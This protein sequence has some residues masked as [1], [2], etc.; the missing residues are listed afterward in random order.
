MRALRTRAACCAIAALATVIA[1]CGD[2]RQGGSAG[3]VAELRIGTFDP[4]GVPYIAAMLSSESLIAVSWEGRPTYRLAQSASESADGALLTVNLRPNVKF[5]NGEIATASRVR[6]LLLKSAPLQNQITGIETSGEWTLVIRVKRPG[7]LRLIDLGSIPVED[8]DDVTVRTGPFRVVS[9]GTT[10]TLE[11]FADYYEGPSSVKGVTVHQYSSHRAAWTAMMRDEVDFLHEVN[12]EAIEFMEA[13]G[14]IKSYPVLRPY[15]VPLVFNMSHP[16]LRQRDVRLALND[17]IDREE[18]VG[19]GM[20]GHGQVAEGP[21]W[22]HHWAYSSAQQQPVHNREAA[23]LRLDAAGLR[24]R[25]AGSGQMPSRFRFVCLVRAGDPRFERIA[26]IVQ[27]QLFDIG[28]DMD[29]QAVPWEDFQARLLKRDFDAFILEMVSF[30]TLTFPYQW[31]HSGARGVSG[32]SAADDALERMKLARDEEDVR[33]AVSDVM[34]IMRADPP[35]V[36]LAWPRDARAA[37]AS[38]DI[39]YQTDR[40]VFGQLSE[41][42]LA[43]PAAERV[44]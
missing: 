32:Y 38:L 7:F 10:A 27:R 40:D 35:A 9:L 15:V 12:R 14:S 11:R 3:P 8:P 6:G 36:F 20:R 31:W 30:R 22:P 4:V 28:V 42:R 29:V 43:A 33:A 41:I 19:N 18:I 17:A 24:V 2:A 13:G 23:K 1:A 34:R 5:H 25:E 26:L 39:P 37:D 16:V 21:F 44:E